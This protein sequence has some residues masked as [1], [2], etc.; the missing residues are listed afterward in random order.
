MKRARRSCSS[1]ERRFGARRPKATGGGK[2]AGGGPLLRLRLH[3]ARRP[4]QHLEFD[5]VGLAP[6]PPLEFHHGSRRQ[7]GDPAD[8]ILRIPHSNAGLRTNIFT[9]VTP[10]AAIPSWAACSSDRSCGTKPSQPRTTWPC[11]RICSM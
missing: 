7:R 5:R 8:E 3:L 9:T 11:F 10:P 4:F 6:V 2:A 1:W